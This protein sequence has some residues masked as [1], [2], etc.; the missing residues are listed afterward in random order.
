[1]QKQMSWDAHLAQRVWD[2]RGGREDSPFL[3]MLAL[4]RA[5]PT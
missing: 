3:R 2:V 1:M 5:S 4:T